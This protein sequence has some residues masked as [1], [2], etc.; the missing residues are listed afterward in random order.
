MMAPLTNLIETGHGAGCERGQSK[1]SGSLNRFRMK[2]AARF[3]F[4]GNAEPFTA[5][6]ANRG[7]ITMIVP[8]PLCSASQRWHHAR[9]HLSPITK[10]L[11]GETPSRSPPFHLMPSGPAAPLTTHRGRF[12]SGFRSFRPSP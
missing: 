2:A 12:Y 3:P 11:S 4:E 6:F 10:R 9:F 7:S 5:K 1:V 8:N